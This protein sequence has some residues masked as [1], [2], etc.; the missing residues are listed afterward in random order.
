MKTS[1]FWNRYLQ[2]VHV[3]DVSPSRLRFNH[4][5]VD[6]EIAVFLLGIPDVG[7]ELPDRRV[8]VGIEFFQKKV[9]CPFNPLG[10]ITVP[11]QAF[12]HRPQ[13]LFIVCGMPLQFEAVITA[14]I[15]ELLKLSFDSNEADC[16]S[17]VSQH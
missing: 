15:S 17:S 6:V 8:D 2:L 12:G 9:A 10:N 1:G 3:S 13:V 16:I 7:N 5:K 4:C 14:G 11:E